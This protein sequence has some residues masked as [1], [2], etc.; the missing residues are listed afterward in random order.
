MDEFSYFKHKCKEH[1]SS[2]AFQGYFMPM[3]LTEYYRTASA[4]AAYPVKYSI[5]NTDQAF[6]FGSKILRNTK[7]KSECVLRKESVLNGLR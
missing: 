1:Q 2:A 3:F 6:R 5:L 4:F 7:A